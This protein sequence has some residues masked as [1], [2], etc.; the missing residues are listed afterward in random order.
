MQSRQPLAN[1]RAFLGGLKIPGS[2]SHL[3][4]P[5][6][7]LLLIACWQMTRTEPWLLPHSEPQFREYSPYFVFIR[8]EITK[9]HGVTQISSRCLQN[10]VPSPGRLWEAHFYASNYYIVYT[11]T[12]SFTSQGLEMM[13]KTNRNPYGI[14]MLKATCSQSGHCWERLP[15]KFTAI[16]EGLFFRNVM[17]GKAGHREPSWPVTVGKLRHWPYL[18]Q[19]IHLEGELQGARFKV[20]GSKT[21]DVILLKEKLVNLTKSSVIRSSICHTT[22]TLNFSL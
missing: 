14:N 11:W 3:L 7:S 9:K 17:E 4:L 18:S 15:H 8:Q 6:Q 1:W 5:I 13:H 21:S 16:P 19:A 20:K 22:K 10:H 12:S 2:N